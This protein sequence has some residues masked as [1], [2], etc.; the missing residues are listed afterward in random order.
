LAVP[1]GDPARSILLE[2]GLRKADVVVM[3]THGRAGLSRLVLGSVASIVLQS[4][5]VP[6]LVIPGK[7]SRDT[8][9]ARPP[10]VIVAL[11]GSA[12][13]RAVI[14][15]AIAFIGNT[16]G[17]ITLVRALTSIEAD[18]IGSVTNDKSA[19]D[20]DLILQDE[21]TWVMQS[22]PDER[23]DVG[24][25]VAQGEPVSVLTTAARELGASVIAIATHGRTGAARLLMGSVAEHLIQNALV[26]ILIR[27]P[28]E[29]AASDRHGLPELPVF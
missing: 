15:D 21:L 11:D 17:K 29:L 12:L 28:V 3:S 1:Y 6:L 4:S 26:P 24:V 10:H 27:R 7:V 9:G 13:A 14:P 23:I 18:Q 19:P 20:K 16:E 2:I 22:M 8:L 5:S 25:R